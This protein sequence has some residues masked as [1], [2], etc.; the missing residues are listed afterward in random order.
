[1]QKFYFHNNRVTYKLRHKKKSN[2]VY[3]LLTVIQRLVPKSSNYSAHSAIANPPI[4]EVCQ[5][6]NRKS[7][8]PQI[9]NLQSSLVSQS[10]NRKSA[11]LQGIISISDQ[12]QHGCLYKYFL[13]G[14]SILY[15]RLRNGI[16]ILSLI[17]L[18]IS[19]LACSTLRTAG[20]ELAVI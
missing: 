8:N 4:S 3:K 12:D 9:P 15:F 6:A 10:E 19:S 13:Q 2:V 17:A 11:N 1:V 18:K 16:V 14:V 7:T 5:S 20:R